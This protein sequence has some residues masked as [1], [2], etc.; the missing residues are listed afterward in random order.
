VTA[1]P[2][3]LWVIIGAGE[4][5]YD[6]WVPTHQDE[7]DLASADSFETFFGDRLA[8]GMLC[9]H[10]WEHLDPAEANVAARNC[11][12]FLLPGARLRVAVPDRLFPDEEYQQMVQVGGPG[13]VDHPAAGHKVTPGF[14]SLILD[15]VRPPAASPR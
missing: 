10:V 4:Q 14:T 5:R 3:P 7:L 8:A 13:P 6:G 12:R 9:E 1:L 11:F 15:A 2:D